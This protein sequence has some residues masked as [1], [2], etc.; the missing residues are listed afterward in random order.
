MGYEERFALRKLTVNSVTWTDIQ[1][2]AVL[3]I[4]A[5]YVII[6]NTLTPPE[7]LLLRSD[8]NNANSEI[9][10]AA[11]AA[12]LQCGGRSQIDFFDAGNSGRVLRLMPIRFERPPDPPHVV[13]HERLTL[14]LRGASVL[15]L[16][17]LFLHAH[18]C[19]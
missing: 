17:L 16:L 2:L 7:A 9:S 4:N 14:A 15:L 11:V 5:N 19:A 13:F 18:G 6:V 8:P 10:I 3:P 1:G 12:R